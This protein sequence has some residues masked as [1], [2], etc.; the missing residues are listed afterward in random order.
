MTIEE[1]AY[2]KINLFL[3]VLGKEKDGYHSIRSVMQAVSLFDDVTVEYSEADYT[4]ITVK[5]ED[6]DIPADERNLAYLAA[7][8]FAEKA[9]LAAAIRITV[10]KRIPVMAGLGGGSSD[11][12]AVLR[13]LNFAT[14]RR[15]TP[16][17]LGKIGATVGADVPFCIVGGRCLCTGYGEIVSALP[18]PA[19][20][21]FYVISMPEEERTATPAAYRML[22]EAFDSFRSADT[23]WHDALY[24]FFREDDTLGLYNIFETVVLPEAPQTDALR[25]KLLSLG[26]RGVLMSGS[27]NAVFAVF[28]DEEKAKEAAK[29]IPGALVCRPVPAL[30]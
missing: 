26:A 5:M 22:D 19:R 15:F 25:T 6:S 7:E 24:D 10:R 8:A 20:D 9:D 27:G 18:A 3:D 4:C 12:A 21:C 14:G 13:A 30:V 16:E 11:A 28:A 29:E 2:A 1:K 23:D 17:E